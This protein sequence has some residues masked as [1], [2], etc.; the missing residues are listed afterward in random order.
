MKLFP[1][2]F[3]I[4]RKKW[5]LFQYGILGILILYIGILSFP[6]FL[7]SQV[8]HYKN[9]RVY[10][11]VDLDSNII[12]IIDS[13]QARIERS[14]LFDSEITHN[15]YLCN[16]NLEYAFFALPAQNSFACKYPGINS[17][18]I[19]VSDVKADIVRKPQSDK[20]RSLSGTMAHEATHNLV[21]NELGIIKYKLLANWKNEGY[22]DFIANESSINYDIGL[23]QFCENNLNHNYFK[24]RLWI[25][26]LIL[27]KNQSFVDIAKGDFST[28]EI[29]KQIKKH[30]CH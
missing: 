3:P 14:K 13:S 16:S 10:A 5:K 19:S 2:S 6:N 11:H 30:H 1:K 12:S 4:K 23:S 18:F 28:K 26:Y 15:V 8:R 20:T 27:H 25:E 22:C 17:I 29:S 21:E 7:F 24:Y 9:F